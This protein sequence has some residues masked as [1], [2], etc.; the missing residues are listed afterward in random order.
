MTTKVSD[1]V[2]PLLTFRLGDQVYA[3]RVDA[4]VEVAA[5]VALVQVIGGNESLL[6]LVNRHGVPMPLLDLRRIFEQ[7]APDPTLNTLFIVAQ[8]Q[9][10]V[11]GLVVDEVLQV[12]YIDEAAL[13]TGQGRYLAGIVSQHERL[14]QVIALSAVFKTYL[15][16]EG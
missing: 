5:M 3:L 15:P 1:H 6:G 7:T 2:Q 13:I 12:E 8:H 16:E 11:V 14:I 9:G 10:R 4:V